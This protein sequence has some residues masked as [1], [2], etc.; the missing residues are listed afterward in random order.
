MTQTTG[1]VT[2][3]NTALA[4]VWTTHR[5]L[6][7]PA[8]LEDDLTGR[9]F[10]PGITDADATQGARNAAGLADWAWEVEGSA[11]RFLS[12]SSSR[13]QGVQVRVEEADARHPA[14]DHPAARPVAR[15]GGVVY[16]I[17]ALGPGNSDRNLCENL[18][19][20]IMLRVD[21]VVEIK[22]RGVKGNRPTVYVSPW[23]G[24]YA[25]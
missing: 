16:V 13:G 6:V 14:P 4:L 24:I 12:L 18:A 1:D 21:G 20:A 8:E 2:R 3:R 10:V 7:A 25:D 23:L 11:L 17:E 5:D 22:G 9:G 15:R 19:E